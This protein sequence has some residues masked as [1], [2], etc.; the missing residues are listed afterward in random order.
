M[1]EIFSKNARFKSNSPFLIKQIEYYQQFIDPKLKKRLGVKRICRHSP[2]CS[3]Y[4]KN[5]IRRYGAARGIVMGARRI[6]RCGR[7]RDL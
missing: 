3:E 4:T 2:T 1:L 5:A 7:P 6:M